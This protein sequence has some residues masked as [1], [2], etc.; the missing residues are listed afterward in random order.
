MNRKTASEKFIH[1]IR[2]GLNQRLLESLDAE[3]IHLGEDRSTVIRIAL[4]F[5]FESIKEKKSGEDTIPAK[6]WNQ[7]RDEVLDEKP[8]LW[9]ALADR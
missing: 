7:I 2:V 4:R 8:E 5:Y 6:T 9:K 1:N 3:C